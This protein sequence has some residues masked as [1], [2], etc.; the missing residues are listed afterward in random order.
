M[1]NNRIY[2]KVYSLQYRTSFQQIVN[3][4]TPVYFEAS[5]NVLKNVRIKAISATPSTLNPNSLFDGFYLT[6]KNFNDENLLYNYPISD[7]QT[8]NI[9]PKN[10]LRLFDLTNINLKS[11]YWIYPQQTGFLPQILF[12]LHF[13]Y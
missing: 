4:S 11:S 8:I 2:D 6:L 3:A 9:S 10:K 1:K 7:L 13:Y 5:Q 12:T